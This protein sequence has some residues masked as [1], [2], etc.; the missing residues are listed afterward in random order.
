MATRQDLAILRDQVAT[1]RADLTATRMWLYG[2]DA[3]KAIAYDTVL[4]LID[5]LK[6]HK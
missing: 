5:D 3:I 1:L 4:A 6:D 2:D